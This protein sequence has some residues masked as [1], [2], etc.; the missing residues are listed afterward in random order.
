REAELVTLREQLKK[1]EDQHR[2]LEDAIHLGLDAESVKPVLAEL[3]KKTLEIRQRI[4]SLDAQQSGVPESSASARLPQRLD[5]LEQAV[6]GLQA[7]RAAAPAPTPAIAANDSAAASKPNP[8]ELPKPT[9]S[10]L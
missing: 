5:A 1:L 3:E 2:N 6:T 4:A 10:K 8:V 9:E 7:A